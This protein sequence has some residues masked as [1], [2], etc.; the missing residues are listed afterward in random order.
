MAVSRVLLKEGGQHLSSCSLKS[1]LVELVKDKL[2]SL[3][4]TY[5]DFLY[6]TV[7]DSRNLSFYLCKQ[8]VY[9]MFHHNNTVTHTDL[10]IKILNCIYFFT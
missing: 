2:E 9:L 3:T 6:N 1:K 10:K 8:S 5:E 4:L 7:W